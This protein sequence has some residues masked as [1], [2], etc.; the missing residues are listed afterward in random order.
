[1]KEMEIKLLELTRANMPGIILLDEWDAN[2]DNLN[3]QKFS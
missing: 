3:I 1:M 2:L